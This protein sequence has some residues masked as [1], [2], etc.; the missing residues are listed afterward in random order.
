MSTNIKTKITTNIDLSTTQILLAESNSLEIDRIK[1]NID[2]KF[3]NRIKTVKSYQEILQSIVEQKPQLL[4]LGKID[5]FNY[6]DTCK[7]CHEIWLDLPI[8]LLSKQEIIYESFLK[9]AKTRGLTDII[10]LDSTNLNQLLQTLDNSSDRQSIDSLQE[11]PSVVD[12]ITG[13]DILRCLDEIVMISNNYFGPLAQG[14]YW[15][16]AHTNTIHKFPS[17]LNWS[18]DHFSKISCANRILE[19]TLT[20]EDIQSMRAWVQFFIS[21]CER[22]IIDFGDIL[23]KSNLSPLT[24][25]LLPKV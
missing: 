16:K 17:L 21:E 11:I 5:K 2:L 9:L 8:F 19:V 4:I 22:I 7:G 25:D 13:G 6:F 24:K 23:K 10:T 3:Q 20:A 1:A 14:N 18:A 12:V 15:R